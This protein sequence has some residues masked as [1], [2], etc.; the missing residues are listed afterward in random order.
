[1]FGTIIIVGAEQA[2]DGNASL[3]P[4]FA[5]EVLRGGS[6]LAGVEVLG[7]SLLEATVENLQSAGV[8]PISVLARSSVTGSTDSPS[9][10]LPSDDVQFPQSQNNSLGSGSHRD[11]ARFFQVEDV[12]GSLQSNLRAHRNSGIDTALVICLAAYVE[13]DWTR[14][15]QFHREKGRPATRLANADGPLDGWMVET[16]HFMEQVDVLNSLKAA[17]LGCYEASGYVNR[18]THPRDLRQFAV[19]A[20][21][22]CCQLR[23][24]GSEIQPGVWLGEGAQ[25]HRGAHI[26]APAFIGRSSIA[27]ED[28]TIADCSAVESDCEIDCGSTLSDVSLLANTYVGIGL[29]LR[30]SVVNGGA[31]L[32][33]EH[34]VILEISDAGVVR[35]NKISRKDVSLPAPVDVQVGEMLFTPAEE[36]AN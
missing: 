17:D 16:A 34:D 25:V 12:A 5:G 14:A 32:S 29:D 8:G 36:A 18:L 28:C 19:D 35:Q 30:H 26:V 22:G 6:P 10:G 13:L 4:R 27:G 15:V 33:L 20:L 9:S 21:T 23:P 11:P 2:V 7:R 3:H 31:V 1:V 24:R